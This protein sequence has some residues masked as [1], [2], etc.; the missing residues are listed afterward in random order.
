MKQLWNSVKNSVILCGKEYKN[1]KN[2][3]FS[4]RSK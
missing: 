1:E 2:V 4:L 3:D